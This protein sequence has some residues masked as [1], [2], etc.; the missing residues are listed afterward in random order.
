[1]TK[2]AKQG[3]GMTNPVTNPKQPVRVFCCGRWFTYEENKPLQR[4]GILTR[5]LG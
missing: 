5:L 1:M 4:E 2:H 3:K